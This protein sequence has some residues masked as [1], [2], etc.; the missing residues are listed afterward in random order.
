MNLVQGNSMALPFANEC[1]DHVV[2]HLDPGD[3]SRWTRLPAGNGARIEARR[4]RADT[5]QISQAGRNR[6]R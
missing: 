3:C 6:R 1:F 2:L 5:G 4:Q